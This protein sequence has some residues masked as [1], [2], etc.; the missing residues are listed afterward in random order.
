[1]TEGS[2]VTFGQINNVIAFPYIFRGA[3]DCRAKGINEEMKLAATRAIAE[4]ARAGHD[5]ED[6][7]VPFS[8]DLVVPKPF[9]ARLREHV[10]AAVADA[11]MRTDMARVQLDIASYRVQL[12]AG[13]S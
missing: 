9:D 1:M 3:L 13:R 2:L 8:R 10:C 12:R 6:G 7:H 11:A 5:D 4:L